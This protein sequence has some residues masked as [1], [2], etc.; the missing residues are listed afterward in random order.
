MCM[1][2]FQFSKNI[3]VPLPA[4]KNNGTGLS[5][6]NR[7]VILPSSCPSLNLTNHSSVAVSTC[8]VV[9]LY[10][11]EW[12]WAVWWYKRACLV[13]FKMDNKGG[14]QEKAGGVLFPHWFGKVSFIIIIIFYECEG[15]LCVPYVRDQCFSQQKKQ[16][17]VPPHSS[18]W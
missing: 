5:A 10:S 18:P 13:S 17:G 16:S 6:V 15:Q 7:K 9:T 4:I 1:L 14:H 11:A 3:N 8:L 2:P 12:K